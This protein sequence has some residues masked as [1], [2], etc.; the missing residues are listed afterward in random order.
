ML[1]YIFA[2][3]HPFYLKKLPNMFSLHPMNKK[4]QTSQYFFHQIRKKT[5]KIVVWL[6]N[7]F[8]FFFFINLGIINISIWY[9][10]LSFPIRWALNIYLM[11]S[12]WTWKKSQI[13]FLNSYN[14]WK[15]YCTFLNVC[16]MHDNLLC[17]WRK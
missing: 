6:T 8:F 13:F 12:T 14:K 17:H 7:V 15:K 10:L 1:L 4:N 9:W 3:L 2:K 16:R 11:S 5:W